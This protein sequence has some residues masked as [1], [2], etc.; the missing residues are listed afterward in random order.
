[1]QVTVCNVKAGIQFSSWTEAV[2]TF[3]WVCHPGLLTSPLYECLHFGSRCGVLLTPWYLIELLHVMLYFTRLL[4]FN[5][6][7]KEV[8]NLLFF[9]YDMHLQIAPWASVRVYEP[10]DRTQPPKASGG[11]S[12]RAPGIFRAESLWLKHQLVVQYL[13]NSLS[14]RMV[15]KSPVIGIVG[16]RANTTSETSGGPTKVVFLG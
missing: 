14:I 10:R 6:L 11:Q 13:A 15:H 4:F 3:P 12:G 1:M 7:L 5:N 9:F 2:C 16:F 8:C